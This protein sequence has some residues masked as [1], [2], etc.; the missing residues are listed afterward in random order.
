MV[1]LLVQENP[2][3]AENGDRERAHRLMRWGGE[4]SFLPTLEFRDMLGRVMRWDEKQG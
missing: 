1:G 3:A 4:S 2:P